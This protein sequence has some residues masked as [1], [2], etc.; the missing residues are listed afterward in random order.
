MRLTTVLC[1]VVTAA[2]VTLATGC[3]G[4][5]TASD[6]SAAAGVAPKASG[7]V[8]G[9]PAGTPRVA[10]TVAQVQGSDDWRMT[11]FAEDAQIEAYT[12]RASAPPGVPVELKVSTSERAYRVSAY[13]IGAYD[14][15]TGHLVHR[16]ALTTGE[17][18]GAP[19]FRPVETR[20]VVAPWE[21]SV[22]LGTQG[23]E[24]G[25]YVLRLAT[26][27]GW[28]NQVPY[29]VSS[30][31]A[32]GTVALVVPV[33]TW[34]AYNLWGGYSLYD[35]PSGDRRSW[36]VSFDRPYHGVGG[37]NDF[38]TGVVPIVIRAEATGVPLSYFANVDLHD[39]YDLL[40][41]AMGYVSTGHDEYW[42]PRM[43]RTVENARDAGT[44][45]AFL[46]ANTAYWRIRLSDRST[47][48]LRLETGYRHD[49][50]LDP[51]REENPEEATGRFRD[52]P[53]ADPESELAG[54]LYECYPVDA[55]YVIASPRWWGF[56][57][58]GVREG[59]AIPG[60]VGGEAD[61]VYPDRRMPRPLQVLSHTAYSCR[62]DATTSQSVYYTVP[63][64]AGVFT[65][66]TLR[67]GCALVDLCDRPLGARTRDFARRVSENVL[68]AFSEG[69][70]G[71]RYPA[72]DNVAE[73]DLPLVNG[74]DAS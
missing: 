20:T 43:R 51:M 45:L 21:V 53:A 55:D 61:R 9:D 33:T 57:G 6:R 34:Q 14:G 64:G 23:W 66:G 41:G 62:G 12:T 8:L 71:E 26:T 22:K 48:P 39:R 3:D 17:R 46:G 36:A 37:M 52:A 58:T 44:N 54:V 74:V 25:F 42:T 4:D 31:S 16:S 27:S 63:S 49:A 10:P 1:S 35:G 38:R 19:V 29:I 67:W 68:R 40:T 18:Q 5:Q 56:A 69:P 32:A 15:G 65:A 47:G 7:K 60:L 59:T 72:Q 24:P 30:P 11:R 28:E 2:M 73:F 50:A 70:V 13:R